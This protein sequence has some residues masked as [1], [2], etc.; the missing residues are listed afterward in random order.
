MEE[1]TILRRMSRGSQ[2]ALE[3][4]MR[5][6]SAYVVTVIHNRSRGC[7]SAEDE[8]EIASDVFL[9]LW[10]HAGEIQLGHLRP[11][12]GSVSSHKTVDQEI[13]LPVLRPL[14]DRHPNRRSHAYAALHRAHPAQPGQ[15][16]AAGHTLPRGISV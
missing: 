8:E 9:S 2:R 6:Y 12:L 14:S 13:L 10:Q 7:L 4:V 1:R 16:R 15:G 5:Q 3:A 11:W